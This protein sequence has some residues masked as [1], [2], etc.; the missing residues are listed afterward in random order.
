L[1]FALISAQQMKKINPLYY[2]PGILIFILFWSFTGIVY[3][4][5]IVEV[6]PPIDFASGNEYDPAFSNDGNQLAYISDKTG[7]FKI[8][9]S[10]KQN[11]AWTDPEEIPEINN[12]KNGIG[13]IRYPSFNYNG[14]ILFFS[15]DFYKDSS[16]VDIFYSERINGVWSD[17]VSIGPP[18]NTADYDGQP[19]I[20][21]NDKTLYF[22][23]NTKSDLYPDSDCKRVYSSQRG[24]SGEWEKP[25]ELPIPINVGCEQFPKIAIDNITLYFAS[26]REGGKGGFDVYKTR[27]IAKN[28]WLPAESLDTMNTQYNDYSPALYFNSDEAYYHIE[29]IDKK[30]LNSKI[31]KVTIPPQFVPGNNVE[32]VGKI[33]ELSTGKPLDSE[34]SVFDPV[35]SRLLTNYKNNSFSGEYQLFL[36]GGDN[37]LLDFNKKDFSHSFVNIEAS[38]LKKNEVISKDIFLY[39]DISLILNVFDNE[40]FKPIAAII[41]IRNSKNEILNPKFEQIKEGRFKINIPIGDKYTFLI[42]ADFFE[43]LSFEFDLTGIVQF[44]EFERDAELV[45]KKVDFQIDISDENSNGIPVDVVIT[46]LDNNEVIYTTAVPTSDGKY[47]VQLREGDR[48]NVSVSPKGYSY[49]NTTVDLKKKEAPKKLTVKLKQLKEDTK[50][51]LENITFEFNSADLNSSS[52]AELDRVVKLMLDNPSIKVEISAHTDNTGSDAY[53]LRL[54][55]RRAKSVLDYLLEQNIGIDRLISQGYGKTKPLVPNDSD[56]NRALNRRV[57]LKIVKIE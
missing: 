46:N 11:G 28:V 14:N 44:D 36:Q 57:E 22:V 25:E 21:P 52:Y 41:E 5:N 12:F 13:N 3:G 7:Q 53:N 17:P 2:Y 30:N 16:N 32:I 27:L 20:S 43:P 6:G 4:Q 49:Y 47:I 33:K 55:K 10:Y 15:A 8:F 18:I 1:N 50:L 45:A 35:T 38:N 42:Q 34:I 24:L 31:F 19:S 56:E 29:Q 40:I 39:K 51:T 23:R 9:I 37:Y 26:L 54:S 48:Y